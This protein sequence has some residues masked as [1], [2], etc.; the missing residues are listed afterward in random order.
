M[1]NIIYTTYTHTCI[2]TIDIKETSVLKQD[3]EELGGT[4]VEWEAQTS[5]R[6]DIRAQIEVSMTGRATGSMSKDVNLAGSMDLC[7]KAREQE[8]NVHWKGQ[9]PL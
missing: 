1:Y 3:L 4:K 6:Y 8:A 9:V 2:G 7:L 5:R